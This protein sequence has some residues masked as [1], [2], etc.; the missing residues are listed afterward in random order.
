MTI[1]VILMKLITRL[2]DSSWIINPQLKLNKNY[3]K[4]IKY[5]SR[6]RSHCV[7]RKCSIQ[8]YEELINSVD[9]ELIS[10]TVGKNF[11]SNINKPHT[12]GS[13]QL[14]DKPNKIPTFFGDKKDFTTKTSKVKF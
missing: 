4:L 12:R 1:Q 13:T 6:Q 5:M 11:P 8:N 9:D 3:I 2:I 7:Y 14:F 10:L